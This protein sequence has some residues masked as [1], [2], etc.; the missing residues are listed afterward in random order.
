VVARTNGV[1]R[2]TADPPASVNVS[3]PG[4]SRSLV[5]PVRELRVPAGSY[6]VTFRSE[7]YAAPVVARVVVESGLSRSVHADFREADPRV[8]VR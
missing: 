2:L 4:K 6:T 7:T 1:L 3:G 5:T 8:T